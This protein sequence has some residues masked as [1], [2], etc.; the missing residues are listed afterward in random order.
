MQNVEENS[1]K[2]NAESGPL[3]LAIKRV[4]FLIVGPVSLEWGRQNTYCSGSRSEDLETNSVEASFP[5][6][7]YSWKVYRYLLLDHVF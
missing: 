3:E 7:S 2:I 4:P 5:R 6:L 1:S